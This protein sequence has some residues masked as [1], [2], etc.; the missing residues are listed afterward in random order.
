[1][2]ATRL[3]MIAAATQAGRD[4][5]ITAGHVTRPGVVTA[6][7]PTNTTALVVADGPPNVD[8]TG[9]DSGPHGAAVAAPVT[10]R[11]GDRVLLL[12]TGTGCFVIGRRQG[13]WEDWHTVGDDSEP[14]Y[15]SAWQPAA[16]TVPPGHNGFA[17]AMFTMRSGLVVLQGRAE[18]VTPASGTDNVFILPEAYWPSNDLF[19][20][21]SGSLGASQFLTIVVLDGVSYLARIQQPD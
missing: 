11:I 10:L 14:P 8:L 5:A 16:G 6:V 15:T 17:P 18:R 9:E 3:E 13:D 21:C 4:A 12:Y 20:R 19:L 7:D 2:D 1:M